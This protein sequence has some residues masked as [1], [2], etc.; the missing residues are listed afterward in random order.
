MTLIVL[1]LA[2]L[3]QQPPAPSPAATPTLT[4][5]QLD[6]LRKITLTAPKVGNL[7]AAVVNLLALGKTGE[8]IGVKQFKADTAV[9]TYVI[10]IPVKP[11]TDDVLFSFRELSG[12]TYTYLSNSSRTLRAAMVSDSDGNRPLS[13]DDAA[14]GF[15][16][17]LKAW[18]LIAPR[19]KFP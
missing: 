4:A 14:T 11:A 16:N 17:T 8:T 13:G 9:G 12:T 18:S 7:D 15:Q 1:A 6:K 19:V 10:T 3:L 2:M 5:E